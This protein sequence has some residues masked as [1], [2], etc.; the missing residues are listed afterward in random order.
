[1]PVRFAKSVACIGIGEELLDVLFVFLGV[2]ADDVFFDAAEHAQ[3]G[4]DDDAGG[5]G[6]L[7]GFGGQLDVLFVRMMGAVDHDA[8]V[9]VVD[10][11][12][13][14]VDGVAVIEVDGDRQLGMFRDGGVDD[15]LEVAHV[16]VLAGAL[17]DLQDQRALLGGAGVDDRLGEFHVVD[18]ERADGKPAVV[19]EVEHRLGGHQRHTNSPFE[20]SQFRKS[21]AGCAVAEIR[22]GQ[23]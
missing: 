21:E 15:G 2:Q 8:G 20:L 9:A 19:G 1:M 22:R 17:G 14:Q 16:G 5:V 13:D 18:V 7:H 10:A 3:F 11:G 6:V 23:W 12:F 4:F